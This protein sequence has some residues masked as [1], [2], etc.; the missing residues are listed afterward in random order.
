MIQ[1]A[2]V[3]GRVPLCSS[4]LQTV[5]VRWMYRFDRWHKTVLKQKPNCPCKVSKT[6]YISMS[7]LFWQ[8]KSTSAR[9]LFSSRRT[10]RWSAVS[11]SPLMESKDKVKLVTF[12]EIFHLYYVLFSYFF[13]IATSVNH[14]KWLHIMLKISLTNMI[15]LKLKSEVDHATTVSCCC[16]KNC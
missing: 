14:L 15:T 13:C 3:K 11:L 2:V 5:T 10:A 12:K 7:D 6:C 16:V 1:D 8:R 9:E 4:L